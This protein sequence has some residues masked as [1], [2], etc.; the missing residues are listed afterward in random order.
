[1]L[2]QCDITVPA[3]NILGALL[4]G[5]YYIR[6]TLESEVTDEF[7][8]IK[9]RLRCSKREAVLEFRIKCMVRKI[10]SSNIRDIEEKAVK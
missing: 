6:R 4:E 2:K 5:Y 10:L 3:V 9:R 7:A 1:M 8:A